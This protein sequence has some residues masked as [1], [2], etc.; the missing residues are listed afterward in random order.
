MHLQPRFTSTPSRAEERGILLMEFC[1][2]K[3]GQQHCHCCVRLQERPRLPSAAALPIVC[4]P[5]GCLPAFPAWCCLQCTA[6]AGVAAA[7]L[8]A[9]RPPLQDLDNCMHAR[10]RAT[11]ERVFS[12]RVQEQ[13]AYMVLH[14]AAWLPTIVI[15]ATATAA[16]CSAVGLAAARVA[17]FLATAAQFSSLSKVCCAPAGT[18]GGGGQRWTLPPG[19]PTCT[20]G[21]HVAQSVSFSMSPLLI[22]IQS[23]RPVQASLPARLVRAG[24]EGA[25][26]SAWWR[27]ENGAGPW[28]LAL[29]SARSA[30]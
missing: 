4:P 21:K 25:G 28:P 13:D 29:K 3:V 18:T 11:G 27:V 22:H 30:H 19:W 7:Q 14:G 2:G 6:T 5:A 16:M 17:A 10:S 9:P 24:W 12:W 1:A 15:A 26:I 8:A 20:T 23:V